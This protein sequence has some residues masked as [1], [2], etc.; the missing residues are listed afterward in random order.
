MNLRRSR[1]GHGRAQFSLSEFR[2][3][4]LCRSG[5]ATPTVQRGHNP[6]FRIQSTEGE[7]EGREGGVSSE[8]RVQLASQL[9]TERGVKKGENPEFRLFTFQRVQI[10][11]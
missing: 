3:K 5:G 1:R 6:E 4:G 9:E 7:R 10:P 2:K 11:R 8:F